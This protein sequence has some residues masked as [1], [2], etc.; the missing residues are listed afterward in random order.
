MLECGD[1]RKGL[2]LDMDGT[3]CIITH[4]EF[5]KPGKG[6]GLYKCKLKNMLTG[7]QFDKTFRSGTKFEKADMEEIEMEYLYNDGDNFCF[8]NN[9]TY[10]QDFLNAELIGEAKNLLK[11][12]TKCNIL[13]FSGKPI[14]ISLP[15]FVELEIEQTEQW[16][17]GD[18]ASGGSKPATL[19][20]GC[21]INVP[22][23]INIGD[24]VKIDTRTGNYVERV[25]K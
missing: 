25:K 3:P 6:T 22:T 13:L 12:N 2:K 5:A 24:M 14:G 7:A 11:E 9:T 18:T 1:L 23:F 4:L 21:V 19:D 15:N 17:K 20:T 10:E 8:M 16:V